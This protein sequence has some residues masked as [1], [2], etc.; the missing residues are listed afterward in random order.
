MLL[1]P[2]VAA[3]RLRW[4]QSALLL[5]SAAVLPAPWR[6][7][8]LVLLTAAAVYGQATLRTRQL[9]LSP[10]GLRLSSGLFLR[11]VL[12][13]PSGAWIGLRILPLPGIREVFL[14]LP[15]RAVYLFPMTEAQLSLLHAHLE[16]AHEA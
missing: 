4:A 15:H 8:A 12:R 14:L 11:E 10:Q 1:S 3:R 13:I 9:H 16:N 2:T 6:G 5:F 7:A